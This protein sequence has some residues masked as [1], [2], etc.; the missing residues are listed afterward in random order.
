MFTQTLSL[1]L[2]LPLFHKAALSPCDLLYLSTCPN[3]LFHPRERK[4]PLLE[5]FGITVFS[6]TNKNS[7]NVCTTDF[8][9]GKKMKKRKKKKAE[10]KI[11]F[12][13][14]KPDKRA[15]KDSVVPGTIS[16]SPLPL[17]LILS[18]SSLFHP[19]HPF[20]WHIT[21]GHFTTNYEQFPS[22][23]AQ[24]EKK[25]SSQHSVGRHC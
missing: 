8:W 2:S 3:P 15:R 9:K 24:L 16:T 10:S 21:G 22:L 14:D 4:N 19:T 23:E 20:C 18:F 12:K 6:L 11:E 7:W 25:C 5:A 13:A 1:P 17:V